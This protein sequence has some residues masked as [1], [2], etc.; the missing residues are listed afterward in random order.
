MNETANVRQQ[1][2]MPGALKGV[3]AILI[4]QGV[5]NAA[6][7]AFLV[8]A[9]NEDVEHGR[10][11][12]ALGHLLSYGSIVIGIAMIGCVFL[13]AKGVSWARWLVA[14]FEALVILSGFVSL[15]NGAPQAVAGMVLAVL[16][17]TTLSKREV[18]DWFAK[19]PF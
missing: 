5:L 4:V 15:L 6:L 14:V 2:R 11:V 7:G 18:D 13:L 1:A 19:D 9:N 10:E 17:L 16:V 8:Y 12:P 3:L